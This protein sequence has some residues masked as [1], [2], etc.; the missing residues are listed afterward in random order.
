MK[1]LVKSI[2]LLFVVSTIVGCATTVPAYRDEAL[3][4][5]LH[6]DYDRA[7]ELYT[8]AIALDPDDPNLYNNRGYSYAGKNMIQQA[9]AD[10]TQAIALGSKSKEPY[11][12]YYNRGLAYL[13]S[14]QF[15]KAVKDFDKGLEL[16]PYKDPLYMYYRGFAYMA[17]DNDDKAVE[18]F[19][20]ALDQQFNTPNCFLY[21]GQIYL[22]K[23]Q[24]DKAIADLSKAISL[25]PDYIDAYGSRGDAYAQL[26]K[27]EEAKKD[28]QKACD[29]GHPG[30]C[31]QLKQMK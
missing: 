16:A 25:K 13:S 29:L 28:F 11:S 24:I 27:M 20:A 14:M 10:Y 23:G 3:G 26:G 7:I 15:D 21:R 12:P 8:K 18:N 17:L 1:C 5:F 4:S 30:F 22:K 6:R 9:I 31:E 2:I 19:S